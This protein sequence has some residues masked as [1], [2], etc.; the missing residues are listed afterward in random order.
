MFPPRNTSNYSLSDFPVV[1]TLPSVLNSTALNLLPRFLANIRSVQTKER[2]T[3]RLLSDLKQP[4]V[5]EATKEA[6]RAALNLPEEIPLSSLGKRT[7]R[8]SE[9]D[10]EDLCMEGKSTKRSRVF[11]Q[12]LEENS[13]IAMMSTSSDSSAVRET[14]PEEKELFKAVEEEK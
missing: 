7:Q 13:W 9:D 5:P 14:V 12:E 3:L 1:R 4:S 8:D 6:I 10:E 11:E 2:L